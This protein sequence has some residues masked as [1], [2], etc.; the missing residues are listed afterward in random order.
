MITAVA[1][2]IY[3][4]KKEVDSATKDDYISIHIKDVNKSQVS[5][6]QTIASPNTIKAVS[7]FK[8]TIYINT[9]KRRWKKIH[10]Y[11]T[12]IILLFV[13]QNRIIYRKYY[14]K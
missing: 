10:Q 1:N 7:K 9:L 3:I 8:A 4:L 5:R 13:F 6:G 11:L 2:K 12:I 14:I